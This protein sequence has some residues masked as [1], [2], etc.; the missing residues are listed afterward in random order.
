MELIHI[1][2]NTIADYINQPK[3]IVDFWAPWCG[4]CVNFAPIFEQA[5]EK[6]PDIQ[7]LK[8]DIDENQEFALKN[9]IRSIPTIQ[10]F[11][12]GEQVFN[13]AGA[14]DLATFKQLIDSVFNS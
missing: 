9:N 13:K 5:A 14:Y 4:P 3:V 12:D 1:N 7:F 11:K 2:E 10:M 6:Y 8:M